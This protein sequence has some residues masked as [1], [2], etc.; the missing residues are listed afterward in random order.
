MRKRFSTTEIDR[1][2]NHLK[3][4]SPIY[5]EEK[6]HQI[7]N[8]PKATARLKGKR[9][10]LLKFTIMTTIF[11]VIISAVLLW[12]GHDNENQ[13]SSIKN[14][15]S[16]KEKAS[17]IKCQESNTLGNEVK[18]TDSK[19]ANNLD[20]SFI[21]IDSSNNNNSGLDA[22][23]Q[24]AT[25]SNVQNSIYPTQQSAQKAISFDP[26][27][28]K[29]TDGSKFV[30][31][32]SNDEL[33]KIGI[34]IID[35]SI[36]YKNVA[37]GY[38]YEYGSRFCKA[39]IQNAPEYYSFLKDEK[40]QK[41]S[42]Y[43][44]GIGFSRK[45]WIE[46]EKTVRK[47]K[48]KPEVINGSTEHYSYYYE[49]PDDTIVPTQLNFYPIFKSNEYFGDILENGT[50][51]SSDFEMAN[52][53]LVPI[54]FP[55][56]KNGS[57]TEEI[58]WFVLTKQLYEILSVK[59]KPL[60]DELIQ[61]KTAKKI[62]P[63]KNL[64]VYR[65][66]FSI[67]ESKVLKLSHNELQKMGFS[68]Y[69]DS[70]IYSGRNSRAQYK[71]MLSERQSTTQTMKYD[72]ELQ[73][74]ELVDGCL[75]VLITDNSG[76]P[77]YNSLGLL[78]VLFPNEDEIYKQIPLLI[79]VEVKGG[80]FYNSLFFWFLPSESFFRAI[81]KEVSTE[82]KAEYDYVIAED[83]SQLEKPDCKYFEECKNTLKVSN[84]KVYPNPANSTATISFSLPE[85]IDGRITLVDMSGRERQ[86]LQPNTNYSK[87]SHSIEVDV[88]SVPE[89]I[90]LITLYSDK[91]IQ[92]Q[93][94]IVAR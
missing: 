15:D 84:F 76:N 60:M 78:P 1:F 3:E 20:N 58:L 68:F 38:C 67:D 2:F 91:G 69:A 63:Q 14:Q 81:S 31:R 25:V 51:N 72:Y 11:A 48:I 24:N 13:V 83:K 29:P 74:P 59:H 17:S 45:S 82:I 94:F 66:P 4:Q 92:T 28:I 54:V 37:N 73:I 47:K 32:L 35:R 19:S 5:N 16:G 61:Y 46:D 39:Y 42:E 40:G 36:V 80:G 90:Y 65:S 64:I 18:L 79:P 56:T 53:T 49:I 7:I 50:L 44:V 34:R 75:A 89:G 85:A 93:R 41:Y 88:S 10:N 87:G 30:L 6:V 26:D 9:N 70:T 27:T 23:Q 77:L 57:D 71:V 33:E 8:S 55:K 22:A 12:T 43:Y 62:F 52:D 86:V 21:V